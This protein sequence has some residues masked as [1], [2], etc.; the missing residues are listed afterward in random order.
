MSFFVQYRVGHD[1]K[2]ITYCYFFVNIL[3]FYFL[4]TY[5][6][7]QASSWVDDYKDWSTLD[8]CCKYFPENGTFCPHE[9]PNCA[10]CTLDTETTTWEEYFPKYFNFFILDNPNPACAKGG[11]PAY[12]TVS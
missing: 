9:N 6:A 1:I 8:G 12:Y 2:N 11:H 7:R 4:R 5:L 10:K 3:L